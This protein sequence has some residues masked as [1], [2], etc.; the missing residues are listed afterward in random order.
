MAEIEDQLPDERPLTVE[1]AEQLLRAKTQELLTAEPAR[2]PAITLELQRLRVATQVL[3]ELDAKGVDPNTYREVALLNRLLH[4]R[5]IENEA[6]K[7]KSADE[8]ERATAVLRAR[9]IEPESAQRIMKVLQSVV[10]AGV[11]DDRESLDEPEPDDD[12]GA[13][14]A[15]PSRER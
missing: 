15:D 1:R 8:A 4:G 14:P 2:I 5:D 7:K 9:G 3:R 11:V 12:P 10:G 6:E 13:E